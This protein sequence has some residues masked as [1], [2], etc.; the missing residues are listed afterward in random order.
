LDSKRRR[1]GRNS[2]AHTYTK[3]YSDSYSQRDTAAN[4]H[5][6]GSSYPATASDVGCIEINREI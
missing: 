2:N 6:P 3:C 4:A 5:P 1:T